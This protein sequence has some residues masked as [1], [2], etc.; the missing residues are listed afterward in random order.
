MLPNQSVKSEAKK[1][2]KQKHMAAFSSLSPSSNAFSS[3]FLS[4]TEEND[5][6]CKLGNEGECDDD[7]D[8]DDDESDDDINDSSDEEESNN[9]DK[10]T[11]TTWNKTQLSAP[12]IQ[13]GKK[14]RT[15]KEEDCLVQ[16]LF[17]KTSLKKLM[18]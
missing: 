8:D 14:R 13:P 17:S 15:K 11:N 1:I 18:L 2:A 6:A 12:W 16:S 5:F 4:S 7:D 9:R 10:K 3:S